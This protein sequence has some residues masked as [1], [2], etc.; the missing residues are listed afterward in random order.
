MGEHKALIHFISQF[1]KEKKIDASLTAN[2]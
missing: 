1:T 2:S